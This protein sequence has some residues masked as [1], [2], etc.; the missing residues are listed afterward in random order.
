M[1]RQ[2]K[3]GAMVLLAAMTF[4]VAAAQAHDETKYPD[5]GGQWSRGD[6][7]AGWDETKKNGLAQNPPLTPEY[8]AIFAANVASVAAGSEVY[9]DQSRCM[10][11]GFPR[12]MIAYEPLEV[13]VTGNTTYVRVDHLSEFRRIYTD[14][15]DWP[16]ELEPT[17]AGYSIGKWIDE[18]G[19]GRYDVLEV[20]TRGIKGPHSYDA[21]GIPFHKDG[22]AVIK[23]RIHLDKDNPDILRDDIT[24]F[25]HALTRPWTVTRSYHRDRNAPWYEH[26]CAEENHHVAIGKES[27]FLSADG[28]LM[29]TRKDQPPPDL[30]YFKQLAK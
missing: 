29:P 28:L 9:N 22:E 3:I 16:A 13:I 18:N 2:S 4:A 6:G 23:E 27:Y 11:S 10:P 25:D 26:V 24:T 30:K 12:M 20:E 5:F 21:N 8:Q 7:G 1:N 17:F 14:G 15:R 19:D